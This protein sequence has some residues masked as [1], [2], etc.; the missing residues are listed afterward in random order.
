[1]AKNPF[2]V[3]GITKE[4][5]NRLTD[6]QLFG[7]V[8]SNYRFLLKMLHPDT[9]RQTSRGS[10]RKSHREAVELNTAFE[11]INLEKNPEAFE[12]HRLNYTAR[13]RKRTRKL[14]DAA[15]ERMERIDHINR[16]LSQRFIDYLFSF[17][18]FHPDKRD[19]S[20]HLEP[21]HI[22]SLRSLRVGLYDVAV[23]YNLRHS[24]WN[25]GR[26]YKEIRFD[27]T[28]RMEYRPLARGR[29]SEVNYI[30]LVGSVE[31]DNVDVIHLLDKNIDKHHHLRSVTSIPAHDEHYDGCEV[32]NTMNPEV[33]REH[34][35]PRLSP[36][37]RENSYLFSV[38]FRDS[39]SHGMP[40]EVHLEGKIIKLDREV[41]TNGRRRHWI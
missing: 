27:E 5:A 29:F 19:Y 30:R 26:N 6:E 21:F 10:S 12:R 14:L 28:G 25:L 3:L 34:C 41:Q 22:F 4:M 1:M 31:A 24:S 35:L 32:L 2:E 20:E 23:G 11:E 37:L 18:E 7:L 39:F 38:H 36:V 15:M 8:R 13:S 17:P 16:E 33:F 9:N 40:K